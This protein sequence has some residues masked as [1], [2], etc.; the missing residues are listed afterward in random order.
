MPMN[1]VQFQPG[2]S[3]PE[4]LRRYGTD[5]QCEAALQIARWPSGFACPGCG[6]AA[7]T[8]FRRQGR[9]YWQCGVCQH[10]C[11]VTSG[12]IFESTK[13][14]LSL[15]FLAMHLLT[16]AKNNVSALELHR[17]LGVSYPTAWLMKHKLLEV[18]RQREDCRQLSGRVEIDQFYA[19]EQG[20]FWG[21]LHRAQDKVLGS[22]HTDFGHTAKAL[23]MIERIGRLARDRALTEFATAEAHALLRRAYLDD[24][25]SWA[26]RLRG[27]GSLDRGKEWWIYAELDQV[28][29][30]LALSDASFARPLAQ[31]YRFWLK[32]TVDHERHEVWGWVS[33]GDSQPAAGPKIHQWKNGY[34]SAEHALVAFITTQALQGKPVTLYYAFSTSTIGVRPYFFVG[35]TVAR[36]TEPLPGFPGRQK[37]RIVFEAVR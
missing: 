18:M 31:T 4:F 12:T 34:H 10:Q 5:A 19:P 37:T 32:H 36:R 15:W 3:M 21:T 20:L 13:L 25:G 26:S 33:G 28:A 22:R 27:D 29:A 7:R 35:T 11:S 30:T 23:W 17:H 1:R 16:Q 9:L 2:L 14:P 24:T 6:G 8:S